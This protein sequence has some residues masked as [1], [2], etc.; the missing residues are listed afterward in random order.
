[1]DCLTFVSNLIDSLAWPVVVLFSVYWLKD[2]ISQRLKGLKKIKWGDNEAEFAEGL[3]A[4]K[5][6]ASEIDLPTEEELEQTEQPGDAR[7]RQVLLDLAKMSPEGAVVQAWREVE[8]AAIDLHKAR[9][10]KATPER[11][12]VS[13][14]IELEWR[15]GVDDSTRLLVRRLRELRNQ[16]AHA[17]EDQ[18]SPAIAS[19]YVHLALSIAEVLRNKAKSVNPT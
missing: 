4:A 11:N 6:E 19:E 7:V 13:Q 16:A 18:I 1:M 14:L 5:K 10:G 3:E 15:D 12:S 2:A 9:G 17:S 8:R